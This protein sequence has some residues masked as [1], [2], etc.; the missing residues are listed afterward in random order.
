MP[1]SGPALSLRKPKVIELPRLGERISYIYLEYSQVHQDS[2]GVIATQGEGKNK[3]TLVIPIAS[4]GFLL[5]GPGTSISTPAAISLHR[6]GT[7]V[8][9]SSLG[10]ATGFAAATPLTG[11]GEWAHAQARAWANLESRLSI[12]RVFYERQFPELNFEPNTP[13][14]VLRGLEGSQVRALY[15]TLSVKAKMPSWKRESTSDK[16]TDAVNPL[17]NLGSAILYGAAT[18]AV[19]AL[20]LNSALGFIHSGAMGALLFDLADIHKPH[21]SIPLA[22]RFCKYDKPA[23]MFR[24]AMREYLYE[25]KVLEGMLTLLVEVLTPYLDSHSKEDTLITDDTTAVPGHQNHSGM[26]DKSSS[27]NE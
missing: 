21:S 8:I 9:F 19:S 3:E 5:M 24:A 13:L 22:F 11:R 6:A 15:K 14:Q 10:G 16:Q 17:L 26:V 23:P 25:E 18:S 27:G 20:G 12:A 2:T 1:Y 7:I 4:I